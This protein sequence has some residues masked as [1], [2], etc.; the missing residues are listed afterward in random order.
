M[1]SKHFKDWYDALEPRIKAQYSADI[2]I[3]L[4]EM[5]LEETGSSGITSIVL[6]NN[7]NNNNQ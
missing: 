3:A 6:N 1:I 4:V 7:N 2:S 5:Y